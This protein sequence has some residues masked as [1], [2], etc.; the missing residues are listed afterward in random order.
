MLTK[1]IYEPTIPYLKPVESDEF[2]NLEV[3]RYWDN[4]MTHKL[5]IISHLL[6]WESLFLNTAIFLDYS[7][8]V[9]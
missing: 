5:Y 7:S 1:Y 3:F 8:F 2:L 4:N 6:C 9:G